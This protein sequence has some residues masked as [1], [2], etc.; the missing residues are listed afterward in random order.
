MSYVYG[1]RGLC[2][3]GWLRNIGGGVFE[4]IWPESF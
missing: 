1:E 4:A 3:Q 2:R